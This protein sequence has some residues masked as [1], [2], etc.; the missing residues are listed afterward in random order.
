MFAKNRGF[1]TVVVL[2]LALGIGANATVFCWVQNCLL[3]PI[4]GLARDAE[5]VVLS[6]FRRGVI[7]DTISLPDLRDYEKL[8]NIFSGVIGSQ[9]T[10]A[11]FD[12]NGDLQWFFGQ[13]ATENFFDVLGVR[14]ILGRGF[15]REEGL[16]PG[17]APVLILSE[18]CWR[19]QFG[20][21][22]GILGRAVMLNRRSFTIVGVMPSEFRGTMGGL[23]CDFWAPLTMHE[24]VANFGSLTRRGDRWLHSQ[25]RDRKSVV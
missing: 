3:R 2:T 25:G 16:K 11:C 1:T 6:S 4:P 22:P 14:P 12:L 19:R 24:E 8:T 13:V 10:P 18:D 23:N 7:G 17:G 20:A 5:F 9:V 15:V 21:D